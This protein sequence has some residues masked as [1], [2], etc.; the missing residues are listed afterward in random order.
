MR[1]APWRSI[2]SGIALLTMLCVAGGPAAPPSIAAGPPSQGPTPA[3]DHPTL[4]PGQPD[5]SSPLPPGQSPPSQP[6]QSAPQPGQP[7][8][9][10][11]PTPPVSMEYKVVNGDVLNIS[12][13]GEPEVS[14]SF[15]VAPDGSITLQ[16][17]GQMQAAGFTLA[18]L[19]KRLTEALKKFIREPQVAIALGQT[20]TRPLVYLLGQVNHP[21]AFPMQPEWT[22][23]ALIA[24][25]GGTTGAAALSRA[26]L[27]RASQTLPVDLEQLLVDGNTSANLPLQAGDV[28]VVPETKARVLLMG[29]V[30]KPGPYLIQPGDHLVDVLSA[31][32]GTTQG[33]QLKDIGV[34]RQAPATAAVA[35]PAGAASAGATATTAGP[36]QVAG[37][38]G[39]TGTKPVVTQID[40]SDFYKNGN[41]KQ[42]VAMQDGD[43]IYVP[44]NSGGVN[45]QAVL[46]T[47]LSVSSLFNMW[48][49]PLH[50]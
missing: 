49:N 44:P 31:A 47:V 34:I 33:A 2:L 29:G 43:V 26:F 46:G 15:A 20:G 39:A 6:D 17:V 48:W 8:A 14:G 25:A 4:A 21:G 11:A 35:A 13:L 42:N 5:P 28:I 50:Y 9:P 16:L 19:T 22:V 18:E 37:P 40:L 1:S 45:W 27:M 7:G 12:V 3:P 23:A 38:T 30:A 10:T 32:G 41:A 24:S 36:A